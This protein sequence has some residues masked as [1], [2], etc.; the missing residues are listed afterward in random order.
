MSRYTERAENIVR[1]VDVTHQTL[2]ESENSSEEVGYQHWKP[3]LRSL[4]DEA[5]FD[6]LYKERSSYNVT[7]FLTFNSDNPSS[8]YSCIAA[9]RE[10]ARMIRDQISSEMWETLNKLYLYV[11]RADA[12]Q[13][14][15]EINFGFFQAIKE[16]TLL[17]QGIIESTFPHELGF[18]Y[19]VCGRQIERADKTCRILDTKTYMARGDKQVDETLEAAQLAAILRGC[20]GFEAFQHDFSA[21]VDPLLIKRFLLLS[22]TFPR[23]TLHC[24]QRLQGAMHAISGCPTSHYSNE[25]ERLTGKLVAK[26]NYST[27]ADLEGTKGDKLIKEIEDDLADIASEMSKQY[28]GGGIYDPAAELTEV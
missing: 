23:S 15:S 9:A 12:N 13:V 20:S 25:S 8:V 22:R 28:M 2:L 1:L 26:L 19:I 18:E 21:E 16:S 17:F 7:E 3:L 27:A 10:N 24:V 6:S 4:G 14:C 11:K 5:L